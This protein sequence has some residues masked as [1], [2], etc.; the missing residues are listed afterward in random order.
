MKTAL[1]L[2]GTGGSNKEYFWFIDTKQ[3]LENKGYKVWWP[4]LPNTEKPE[5]NETYSFISK[6]LPDIDENT[7]IIGHS[8]AC[9]L[10]LY[11]L[12]HIDLTLNS[13]KG[14]RLI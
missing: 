8:S 3:D 10:I 6:N 7:I 14:K 11:L 13:C 5:L 4:L 9:P 12:E 2:H 1:L